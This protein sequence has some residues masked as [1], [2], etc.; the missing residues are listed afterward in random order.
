MDCSIVFDI[1]NSGLRTWWF[2]SAGLFFVAIGVALA[3]F[4]YRFAKKGLPSSFPWLFLG[5]SV[6]WTCL[7]TVATV[8]S[9]V[10]LRHAL[11]SGNYQFVEGIVHNF[12]PMPYEGHAMESFDVAGEHFEYSDY[13]IT[14]GFNNTSSHGGP[15]LDGVYVRIRHRSGTILHLEICRPWVSSANSLILRPPC[16]SPST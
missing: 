3:R 9:Y 14:S 6:F 12:K 10:S 7:T 13:D 5:F 11:S 15:I 2:P 16:E 4:R 8:G 1:R